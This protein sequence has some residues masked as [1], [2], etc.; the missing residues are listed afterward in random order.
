METRPT[1]H[2]C[3][4]FT[5]HSPV[6]CFLFELVSTFLNMQIQNSSLLTCIEKKVFFG[7]AREGI[8][9][10]QHSAGAELQLTTWG[11]CTCFLI[12]W[13]FSFPFASFLSLSYYL[14][15]QF[16]LPAWVLEV[17]ISR[18]LPWP[19]LWSRNYHLRRTGIIPGGQG[20]W[21]WLPL[22][23][24]GGPLCLW[25]SPLCTHSGRFLSWDSPQQVLS[26]KNMPR[27]QHYSWTADVKIRGHPCPAFSNTEAAE[28]LY[29]S[30]CSLGEQNLRSTSWKSLSGQN[31]K[32]LSL[33]LGPFHH[34]HTF[35]TGH[36]S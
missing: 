1:S 27:H 23:W 17:G 29:F 31:H 26:A 5:F 2:R 19:G 9:A 7:N 15:S 28:Q 3:V 25:P 24:L 16:T 32:T 33:Y 36:H 30:S 14:S 12:S 10:W 4:L 35:D 22:E 20:D 6:F 21:L 18:S 8:S 11:G 34:C 13:S